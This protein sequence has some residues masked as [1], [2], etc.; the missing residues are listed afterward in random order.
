MSTEMTFDEW[1]KKYPP[2]DRVPNLID[3]GAGWTVEQDDGEMVATAFETYGAE[4]EFVLAQDPRNVW[5]VMDDGSV[6]SGIHYVNRM[7]YLITKRKWPRDAFITV[8]DEFCDTCGAL[9][10]WDECWNC[11]EG[12]AE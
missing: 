4:L 5:T 10:A 1:E 3:D 6:V 11:E 2:I 12:T 8:H 7:C 9:R